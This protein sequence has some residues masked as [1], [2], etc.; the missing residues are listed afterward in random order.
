MNRILCITLRFLDPVPQFHGRTNEG[1]P[2]WPPSP[3]R[4]FQG[5]VASATRRWTPEQLNDTI[6]PA[7]KWLETVI[8]SIVTP[9]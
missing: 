4:L 8:P 5:M 1:E 6:L 9:L 7:L 2:E 3:L